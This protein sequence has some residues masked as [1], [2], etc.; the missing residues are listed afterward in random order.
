MSPAG[1]GVSQPLAV[2]DGALKVT[3]GHDPSDYE[4]GQRFGLEVV[5]ILDAY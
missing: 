4:R 1:Q 2:R 5:S 3:P